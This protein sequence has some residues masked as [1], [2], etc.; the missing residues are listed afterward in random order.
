MDALRHVGVA[1]GAQGVSVLGDEALLLARVGRECTGA[2]FG[3]CR[4]G[5]LYETQVRL[6]KVGDVE[7]SAGVTYDSM[8]EKANEAKSGVYRMVGKEEEPKSP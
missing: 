8:C 1:Q 3:P 2:Q 5:T 4:F 7:E 6:C